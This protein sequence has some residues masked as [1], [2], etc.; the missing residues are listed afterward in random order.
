MVAYTHQVDAIYQFSA[1]KTA[2]NDSYKNVDFIE[3][4]FVILVPFEYH[5]SL[6]SSTIVIKLVGPFHNYISP[7]IDAILREILV[8]TIARSIGSIVLWVQSG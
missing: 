6:I 3:A 7:S 2:E 1:A 5:K 8:S 4:K